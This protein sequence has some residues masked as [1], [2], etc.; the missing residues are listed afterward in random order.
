[1]Y[2]LIGII[3]VFFIGLIITFTTA[4]DLP[5]QHSWGARIILFLFMLFG[6]WLTYDSFTTFKN[7]L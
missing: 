2:E 7:W 6:F 5:Y 4:T 3:I 1:M